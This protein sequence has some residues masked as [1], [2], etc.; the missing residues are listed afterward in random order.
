MG[1]IKKYRFEFDLEILE[2]WNVVVYL[3]DGNGNVM[4]PF[5]SKFINFL[6]IL[7]HSSAS[8]ERIFSCINLNKTKV[9]NRLST[10]SLIELLHSKN[11]LNSQ[12]KSE[13]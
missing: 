2:F 1:P 9:R 11:I 4:F 3:N 10:E 8:V 6:I 5:L 12:Q 7:L 13:S